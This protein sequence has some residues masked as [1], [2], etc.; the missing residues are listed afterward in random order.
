MSIFFNL[1]KQEL[2]VFPISHLSFG[3]FT[4]IEFMNRMRGAI[5]ATSYSEDLLFSSA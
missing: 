5:P 1:I 2:V 4:L 3:F